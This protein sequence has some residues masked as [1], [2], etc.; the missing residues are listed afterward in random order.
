M[1]YP[2]VIDADVCELRAA[3]NFTNG[4]NTGCRGLQSLVDLDIS[5]AGEFNACRLEA[6]HLAVGSATCRHQQM[7]ASEG[8]R[9]PILLD[10]GAHDVSRLARDLLDPGIQ[11][12]VDPFVPKQIPN[13]LTHV[14][15]LP[16]HQALVP[17]N[18]RDSAAK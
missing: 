4:P 9:S 12:N 14:F 15:I 1:D 17:I 7:A 10:N 18:H 13:S 5:T 2:E 11:K 8:I 16:G 3:C 6:K